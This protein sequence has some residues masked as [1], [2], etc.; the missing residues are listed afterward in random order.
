M[1]DT[2]WKLVFDYYFIHGIISARALKNYVERILAGGI[3]ICNR[4]RLKKLHKKK[5]KM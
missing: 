2:E 4:K 5:L 1:S 3:R